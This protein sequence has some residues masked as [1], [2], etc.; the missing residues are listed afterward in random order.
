MPTGTCCG[1]ADLTILTYDG[2]DSLVCQALDSQAE[3]YWVPSLPRS[4]KALN[5]KD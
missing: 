5:M 2:Q 1:H 3:R 4:Q